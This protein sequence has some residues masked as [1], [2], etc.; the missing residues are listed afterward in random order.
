MQEQMNVMLEE[1]KEWTE[2]NYHRVWEAAKQFRPDLILTGITTLSEVLAVGQ[3]LRV[4][5][6]AACTLPIYP[7]S[8]W[9]PVTAV[10][11]P[12][13]LGFL[14]SFAQWATFKRTLSCVSCVSRECVV[15][16]VWCV[17]W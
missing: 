4:P 2:P 15:R 16:V 11:K 17:V 13:P 9:A 8:E 12:L 6:V 10:A 1:T 5:V 14:N 3:K 7:T